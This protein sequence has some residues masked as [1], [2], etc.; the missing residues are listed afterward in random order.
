MATKL[1]YK[2]LD[3]GLLT[4]KAAPTDAVVVDDLD[5]VGLYN[6]AR[7]AWEDCWRHLRC[8]ANI[9]AELPCDPADRPRQP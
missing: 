2:P 9:Y 3:A 5:A 4:C 7:D 6:R 8:I 1:V